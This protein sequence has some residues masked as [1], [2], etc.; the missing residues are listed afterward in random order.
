MTD[1]R[2][3]KER[4]KYNIPLIKRDK[5]K[6]IS[7]F[8]HGRRL[9]ASPHRRFER[10]EKKLRRRRAQFIKKQTQPS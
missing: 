3:N 9:R 10:G 5:E 6:D 8:I 4:N 1:A 2:S 7:V